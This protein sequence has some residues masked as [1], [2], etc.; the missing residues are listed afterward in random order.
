MNKLPLLALTLILGGCQAHQQGP[1]F[2]RRIFPSRATPAVTPSPSPTPKPAA[3]S[4]KPTSGS[5]K[6]KAAAPS[7][8]ATPAP[9]KAATPTPKPL[10]ERK[11]KPAPIGE[12]PV[13]QRTLSTPPPPPMATPS[14]RDQ[15][16]SFGKPVPGKP[17][18]VTSPYTSG[19]GYIDVT[20][21]Q[22]GTEARDPY[23][24]RIF[25]VP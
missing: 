10:A 9:K 13:G 2:F 4:A 16:V 22:P 6:P 19:S 3:T 12:A 18:F 11:A 1:G 25:K 15:E 23:S 14:P 5:A 7:K 17:G 24:G 20:G 21:L 8:R